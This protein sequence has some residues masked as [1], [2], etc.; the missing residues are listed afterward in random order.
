MKPNLIELQHSQIARTLVQLS[1]LIHE[2][3]MVC[4]ILAVSPQNIVKGLAWGSHF[5]ALIVHDHHW[6][7]ARQIP[8]E[9]LRSLL[10]L[11]EGIN[12]IFFI[13]QFIQPLGHNSAEE[14]AQYLV[15]LQP[16]LLCKHTWEQ[17]DIM[18]APLQ[19]VSCTLAPP[20]VRV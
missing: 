12:R 4:S 15:N 8:I 3:E 13:Q 9:L 6:Y 7:L 20:A 14:A 18:A 2:P 11:I 10:P 17:L 1:A 5:N 19:G 16:C